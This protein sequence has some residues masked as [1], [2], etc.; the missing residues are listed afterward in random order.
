MSKRNRS[1][2]LSS[3]DKERYDAKHL[4]DAIWHVRMARR[5][6]R[7]AD[8]EVM[9]EA[10]ALATPADR[11]ERRI[12]APATMLLIRFVAAGDGLRTAA[13]SLGEVA[14]L[15]KRWRRQL[16]RRTRDERTR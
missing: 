6:L 13:G 7:K 2:T 4:S 16:E 1:R 11:Q 5:A 14:G 10:L 9:R 3:A 8:A 15:L 12:G